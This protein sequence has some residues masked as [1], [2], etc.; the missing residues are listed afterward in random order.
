M[1]KVGCFACV[2]TPGW[3]KL[4]TKLADFFE[5]RLEPVT[6]LMPLWKSEHCWRHTFQ[7]SIFQLP[8][9]GP[10]LYTRTCL[11]EPRDPSRRPA[12]SFQVGPCA[13][14]ILEPKANS[15]ST[16]FLPLL[17]TMLSYTWRYCTL[18]GSL[19]GF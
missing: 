3:H 8:T 15:Q 9:G 7:G 16:G 14:C 19:R 18:L 5:P 10:C 2:A 11:T 1:S 17:F 4:E 12:L 13:W 6:V